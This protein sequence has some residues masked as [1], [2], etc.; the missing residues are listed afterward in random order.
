MSRRLLLLLSLVACAFTPVSADDPNTSLLQACRRGD[1]AT[2]KRLVAAGANVNYRDQTG[3]SPLINAAQAHALEIV[4]LLVEKGANVNARDEYG[5]TGLLYAAHRGYVEIVSLLLKHRADINATDSHGATALQWATIGAPNED[6]EDK[7]P[8]AKFLI[9]HG[10]RVNTANKSGKTP[11]ME[12]AGTGDAQ[13]V[14]LLLDHGASIDMKNHGG[15]T[16]LMWSASS[17][18]YPAFRVLVEHGA[19][20]HA[21]NNDGQ[22]PLLVAAE[23]LCLP[24]IKLLLA[25]G[26]DVHARDKNERNALHWVIIG[27]GGDYSEAFEGDPEIVQYL[28]NKGVDPNQKDSDGRTVLQEAILHKRTAVIPIL[29]Q[30][31]A[32]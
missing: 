10:A 23:N 25:H 15:Y 8:M 27:N 21:R 5:G 18:E 6:P 28:L 31:G 11:L 9:A 4:Q 2:A 13:T 29:R 22:T 30:H 14:R 20:I 26:A 24:C 7:F 19:D 3:T 16:A 32:R 12:A 17:D 1:F